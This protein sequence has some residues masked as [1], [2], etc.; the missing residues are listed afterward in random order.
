[1]D[2]NIQT[3]EDLLIQRS[4]T[5]RFTQIYLDELFYTNINLSTQVNLN[6]FH[7]VLFTI[8]IHIMPNQLLRIFKLAIKT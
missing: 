6:F 1:M 4:Q 3:V 8:H 7:L 5:I 2:W